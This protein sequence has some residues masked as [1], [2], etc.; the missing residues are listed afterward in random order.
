ML[1]EVMNKM[2]SKKG[3]IIRLIIAIALASI[4]LFQK[5]NLYNGTHSK[6][7]VHHPI[8]SS[9]FEED[10]TIETWSCILCGEILDM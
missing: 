5:I 10:G 3:L 1:K 9:F 7:H 6:K 4:I 8:G 2:V